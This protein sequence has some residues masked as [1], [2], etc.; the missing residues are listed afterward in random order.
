MQS[1]TQLKATLVTASIRVG[2]GSGSI[3]EFFTAR[4]VQRLALTNVKLA[5]GLRQQ[6]HDKLSVAESC[7]EYSQVSGVPAWPMF[8]ADCKKIW[9]DQR[10]PITAIQVAASRRRGSR[11]A[12]VCSAKT[13][14]KPDISLRTVASVKADLR[15]KQSKRLQIDSEQRQWV[16]FPMKGFA[17]EVLT[18]A[19]SE[20]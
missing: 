13:S 5:F 15:R 14:A 1:V 11:G 16:C 4:N 2:S 18:S 3:R 9:K 7:D 17:T 20:S 19:E 8:C 12:L 10:R 6:L